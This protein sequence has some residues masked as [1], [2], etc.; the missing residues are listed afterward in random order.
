MSILFYNIKFMT[1]NDAEFFFCAISLEKC[2]FIPFVRSCLTSNNSF[3]GYLSPPALKKGSTKK[4][5]ITPF[6]TNCKLGNTI[7]RF[8]F[9]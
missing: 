1:L 3:K 5:R 9:Y 2:S 7:K 8:R 6:L 4:S